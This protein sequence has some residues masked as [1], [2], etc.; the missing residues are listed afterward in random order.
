MSAATVQVRL[1]SIDA[2]ISKQ[3][4]SISW[5]QADLMFARMLLER[6]SMFYHLSPTLKCVLLGLIETCF[7]FSLRY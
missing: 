4:C 6:P 1:Y 3:N 2:H 5:L 7:F